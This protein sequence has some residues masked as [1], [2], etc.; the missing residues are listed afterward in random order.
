MGAV[1]P[2]EPAAAEIALRWVHGEREIAQALRIRREV[3][4]GEQGVPLAEEIDGRDG[5]AWHLLAS[6]EGAGVVGTLRVLGAEGPTAKIG[7]VAVEP[8]WRRRGLASAMLAEALARAA[9]LGAARAR[10]AAQTSAVALY[11]SAGFAVES[12]E[13]EE[14]GIAHVWMGRDL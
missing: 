12:G 5:D 6:V 4:C 9:A 2:E 7:R 14:A 8:A 10:L 11:E 13:F 1:D 3:F